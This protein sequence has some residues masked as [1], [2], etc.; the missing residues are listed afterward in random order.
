M[1]ETSEPTAPAR[2]PIDTSAFLFALILGPFWG[3]LVA[4]AI[5]L[6]PIGLLS[7]TTGSEIGVYALIPVFGIAFGA[8]LYLTLG[9]I[10]FVLAARAR[11]NSAW[12]YA[13]AAFLANLFSPLVLYLF[14]NASRVPDPASISLFYLGFGS[15]CAP[16]YGWGFGSI[17]I[18]FTKGDAR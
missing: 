17:Y 8:P 15:A 2:Y 12:I 1:T 5:A 16:I 4:I 18:N 7:L 9:T 13:L 6:I 3:T 10:A 14:A 11:A